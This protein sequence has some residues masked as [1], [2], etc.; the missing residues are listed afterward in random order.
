MGLFH[1]QDCNLP[2]DDCAAIGA[3]VSH[4][5]NRFVDAVNQLNVTC[6]PGKRPDGLPDWVW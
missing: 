5:F 6:T 3:V 1:F 2:A 4:S